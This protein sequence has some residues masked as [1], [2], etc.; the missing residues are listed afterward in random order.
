MQDNDH[1][2]IREKAYANL[3]ERWTRETILGYCELS[4]T[5]KHIEFMQACIV[6]NLHIKTEDVFSPKLP[7]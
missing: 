6:L 4:Q 2:W 1:T 5:S 7:N 3:A